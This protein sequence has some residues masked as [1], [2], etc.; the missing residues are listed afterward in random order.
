MATRP[1]VTPQEVRD[2]TDRQSVIDRTD[3]K[4]AIDIARAELYVIKYT[5]NR[6]DDDEKYPTAPEPIKIAVILIAEAYASYAID[7]GNG[8]G[9][10]KSESFDDY[11]YTAADMEYITSNLDLSSLLEEYIEPLTKNTVT[12]R[13]RKL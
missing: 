12:M 4:L 11:S 6:F 3:E 8:A 5:R 9:T 7:F 1:W 10:Y 13:M 2:Y